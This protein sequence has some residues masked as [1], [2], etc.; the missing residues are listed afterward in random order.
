MDRTEH[1]PY[2]PPGGAWAGFQSWRHLLFLHWPVEGGIVRP[3]IPDGLELDTFD[4]QAWISVVPFRIREA[5]ARGLPP[6]PGFSSVDEIN[7]RTYVRNRHGKKGV[8]FLK[9]GASKWWVAAGARM[10]FKLPYLSASISMQSEADRFQL[11]VSWDHNRGARS[12]TEQFDCGYRPGPEKVELKPGTLDY[13][14]TER[15]CLFTAGGNGAIKIGEIHH[16]PWLL[17]PVEV[18]IAANTLLSDHGI[19]LNGNPSIAAYSSR[20]DAILWPIREDVP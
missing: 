20:Q 15:Y 10:I 11:K 12:V 8:F 2:P 6:I 1:R 13:W 7:V 3:Y 19:S 18:D 9:I 14:L 4:G 17:H 16:R 5:R